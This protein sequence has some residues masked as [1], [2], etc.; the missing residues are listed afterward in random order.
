MG[1]TSGGLPLFLVGFGMAVGGAYLL[2]NQVMVHSRYWNFWGEHTFGL[3]LL[4]LLF[5]VGFLFWDGRSKI[6]WLLSFVGL[7]FM[8][9][10]IIVNLEIHFR[11]TT[12]F[13]TLMILT[14]LVGGLGMI[15]R[16]LRPVGRAG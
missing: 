9:L 4:P 16:S 5:G 7:V 11:P 14:L 3:T 15:A 1:G 6:G 10:G 8:F 2:T 12:L 13:N